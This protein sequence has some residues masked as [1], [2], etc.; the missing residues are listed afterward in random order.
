MGA[1]AILSRD[2][3]TPRLPTILYRGRGCVTETGSL[4]PMSFLEINLEVLLLRS[5]DSIEF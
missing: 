2:L 5:E 1:L 3:D 4:Q